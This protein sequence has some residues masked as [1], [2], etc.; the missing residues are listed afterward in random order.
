MIDPGVLCLLCALWLDSGADLFHSSA[1]G[2]KEPA[3]WRPGGQDGFA[4]M[5]SGTQLLT[6]VWL[7]SSLGK[8]PPI[9][10]FPRVST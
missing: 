4:K 2:V 1:P 5:D 10:M 3:I 6:Y 7:A 8:G 9:Q